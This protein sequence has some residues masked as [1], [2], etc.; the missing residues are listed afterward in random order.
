[1]KLETRHARLLCRRFASIEKLYFKISL[2]IQWMKSEHIILLY[3][4]VPG[5]VELKKTD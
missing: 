2:I 5:K 3:S 1:M 4:L